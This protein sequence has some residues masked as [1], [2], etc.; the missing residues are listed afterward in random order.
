MKTRN[1]I[2]IVIFSIAVFFT[3]C[4][5]PQLPSDQ[6]VYVEVIEHNQKSKEAYELS[7]MWLANAFRD[8]KAVIEYDNS[9]KGTVI[10]KGILPN[11]SYGSITYFDTSFTLEINV[12]DNKSKIMFSRIML[13]PDTS[14]PYLKGM[15]PFELWNQEQLDYFKLD[16]N[17]RLVSEY[18]KYINNGDK[19]SDW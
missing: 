15:K 4:A 19:K 12:K 1:L 6:R 8:S 2:G 10:G 16:A 13:I 11:V 3:G 5:Q 18:K 9:D 7:K 14:N 17:S